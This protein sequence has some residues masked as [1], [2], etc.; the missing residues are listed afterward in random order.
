MITLLTGGARSGKS[1]KALDLAQGKEPQTLIATAQALD[2]E[3]A[4][5]I[6]LHRAERG[7]NWHVIEEPLALA[8]AIQATA[9][10]SAVVLVDCLTLWLS[11]LFGESEKRRKQEIYD[12]LS[13]LNRPLPGELIFVTNELG[14]GLVPTEAL[15]RRFRDEMGRLN[16]EIAQ[17][18]DRVLF[19]VSGLPLTLKENQ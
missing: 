2:E 18:A 14:L 7:A 5:R 6:A 8:Q 10:K 9:P 4:Q 17:R 12:L 1:Q 13:L 3:M 15:S 16:Q 19:M 11:N